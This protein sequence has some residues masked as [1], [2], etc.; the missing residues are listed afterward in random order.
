[1][2]PQ[3][4]FAWPALAVKLSAGFGSGASPSQSGELGWEGEGTISNLRKTGGEGGFWF[5][6]RVNLRKIKGG[7]EVV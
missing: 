2:K 5:N 1:M 3:K 6:M 7:R 4:I